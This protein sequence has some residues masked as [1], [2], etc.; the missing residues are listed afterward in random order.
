MM[1]K[2]GTGIKEAIGSKR[3]HD[4]LMPDV[5]VVEEGYDEQVWASLIAKG[6]NISTLAVAASSVQGIARL[7][8]GTFE[9]AGETRQKDSGGLVV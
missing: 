1:M 8:D 9:A 6:H 2:P 7:A 4:Q 5:L 3:L